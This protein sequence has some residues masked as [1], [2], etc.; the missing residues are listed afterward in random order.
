MR[1]VIPRSVLSAC[2]GKTNAQTPR[3]AST[4]VLVT[5]RLP[6]Y[7]GGQTPAWDWA[8]KAGPY[9]RPLRFTRNP[10]AARAAYR[11]L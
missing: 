7:R 4:L 11:I 2:P 10:G 8:S 1:E 9:R 5:Q 3:D 6:P